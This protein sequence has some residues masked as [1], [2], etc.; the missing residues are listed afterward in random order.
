MI[1]RNCDVKK[2]IIKTKTGF[3]TFEKFKSAIR[4]LIK[5]VENDPVLLKKVWA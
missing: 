4:K 3:S 2:K 5:M 1:L